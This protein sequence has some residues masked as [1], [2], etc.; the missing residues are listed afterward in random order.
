MCGLGFW[1]LL[2]RAGYH[3]PGITRRAFKT[4]GWLDVRNLYRHK[5]FNIQKLET[6]NRKFVSEIVTDGK[7]V[8]ILMRKPKRTEIEKPIDEK[9]FDVRC[10]RFSSVP[11]V[12]LL[13]QT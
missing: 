10:C 11:R 8:S 6:A 2:R 7:A 5:L 9:D 4:A 12:S 3:A 13:F 1:A